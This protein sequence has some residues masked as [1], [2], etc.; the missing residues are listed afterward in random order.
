ME[1]IKNQER[2]EKKASHCENEKLEKRRL[3]P[4]EFIALVFLT[5]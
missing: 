1:A 4:P 2:H 3:L 5:G